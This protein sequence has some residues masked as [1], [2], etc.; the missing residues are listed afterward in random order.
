MYFFVTA[1]N[2]DFPSETV[3][4]FPESTTFCCETDVSVLL[5]SLSENKWAFY[6]KVHFIVTAVNFKRKGK[7]MRLVS[8]GTFDDANEIVEDIMRL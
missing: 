6:K 1:F 4:K 3:L 8:E 5:F 2:A 7:D